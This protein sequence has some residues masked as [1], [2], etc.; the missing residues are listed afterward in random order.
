MYTDTKYNDAYRQNVYW[1]SAYTT[2]NSTKL[3]QHILHSI[4]FLGPSDGNLSTNNQINLAQYTST[5][6]SGT[7]DVNIILYAYDNNA[8]IIRFTSLQ[9][10]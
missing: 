7:I 5:A 9:F 6:L 8:T 3:G 4:I 1:I 10:L 2:V